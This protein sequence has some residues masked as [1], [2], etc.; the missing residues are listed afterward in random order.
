MAPGVE[1]WEEPRLPGQ[2][3]GCCQTWYDRLLCPLSCPTLRRCLLVCLQTYL[4]TSLSL[5][6]PPPLPCRS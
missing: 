3:L 2:G 1:G 5:L 6:V 4:L